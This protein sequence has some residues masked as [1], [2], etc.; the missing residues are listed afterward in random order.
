MISIKQIKYK[1]FIIQ[2][3]PLVGLLLLL[4]QLVQAQLPGSI[5]VVYPAVCHPSSSRPG[6]HD[7]LTFQHRNDA[8]DSITITY[9]YLDS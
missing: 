7:S 5:G 1:R 3:R 6:G 2:P 4:T 8:A 9:R